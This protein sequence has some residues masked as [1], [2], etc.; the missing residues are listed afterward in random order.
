VDIEVAI[1]TNRRG[2]LLAGE[3]TLIRLLRGPASTPRQ[4]PDGTLEKPPHLDDTPD[5]YLRALSGILRRVA[6][7]EEL[8]DGIVPANGEAAT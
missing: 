6:P 3:H 2:A 4:A 8:G 5:L 1:R 7:D